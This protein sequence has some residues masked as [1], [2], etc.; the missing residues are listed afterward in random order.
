MCGPYDSVIGRRT[1]RVLS[2]FIN[3]MPTAFDVAKNDVR[4][5]GI[6]VTIDSDTGKAIRIKRINE[7]LPPISDLAEEED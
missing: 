4:L 3:G 5:S 6:I 1:D 2:A 7:R